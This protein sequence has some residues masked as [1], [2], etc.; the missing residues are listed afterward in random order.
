MFYK[1]PVGDGE[2]V[3]ID[4][5]QSPPIL[6]GTAYNFLAFFKVQLS[7]QAPVS[8]TYFPDTSQS[9]SYDFITELKLNA[10]NPRYLL[11]CTDQRM[12]KINQ[13]DYCNRYDMTTGNDSV[14][15]QA[16]TVVKGY[17]LN[18]YMYGG[19][20]NGVADESMIFGIDYVNGITYAYDTATGAHAYNFTKVTFKF[21]TNCL[22]MNPRNYYQA[23]FVYDNSTVWQ[24]LDFG[25]TWTDVTGT[26]FA[27]SGSHEMPY[28]WGSIVIPMR[29][30]N[31]LVI[32][33][34]LGVYVAFDS[35]MGLSTRWY[36]LGLSMPNVL[37][38][39]FLYDP[40]KDLLVVSTMGRG[41][42]TLSQVLKQ[43]TF[44][45]HG[46]YGFHTQMRERSLYWKT[47]DFVESP[48]PQQSIFG[49]A[50]P[51]EPRLFSQVDTS[52]TFV[53]SQFREKKKKIFTTKK[54]GITK[55]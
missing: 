3:A 16:K 27:D 33:T 6:Y 7:Q 44:L 13:P 35:Q 54:V 12:I 49:L 34:A 23:Y 15:P 9:A 21:F 26:L 24:T 4:S 55:N 29:K 41:W 50:E 19:Y 42:W 25:A 53:Q 18:E 5:S 43:L 45:K 10:V 30:H 31:A 36:K 2:G 47:N 32:G 8:A 20:R 52:L 37:I 14:S 22:S 1:V 39:A 51:I 11:V 17:A 46:M 48:P 40:Q 28:A 38:S